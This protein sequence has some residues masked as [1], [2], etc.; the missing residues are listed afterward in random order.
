MEILLSCLKRSRPAPLVFFIMIRRTPRST[1]FPYTTLFRSVDDSSHNSSIFQSLD[2]AIDRKTFGDPA[3]INN[4][5]TAKKDLVLRA[6]KN[7]TRGRGWTELITT[8]RKIIP[9]R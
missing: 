1:L 5:L 7:I 3:K 4:Q 6:K 9:L 8:T 2:G